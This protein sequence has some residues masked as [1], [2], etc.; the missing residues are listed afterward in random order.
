MLDLDTEFALLNGEKRGKVVLISV[1]DGFL[2]RG[3]ENKL[4]EG[5]VPVT[6][7]SASVNEIAPLRDEASMYLFNLD[8]GIADAT[9]FLVYLK[10][11]CEEDTKRILVVGSRDEYAFV[12]RVI[13]ERFVYEWL[14]R[15]LD[16]TV[17]L[18]KTQACLENSSGGQR[19]T[20]LIVD[21]DVTYVKIIYEWL[22]DTYQVGM[23]TSGMQAITWLAKH[24]TDLILLDYEMPV[25]SGPQVL[26][27]LKSDSETNRVPV[28]FLTG[29]GDRESVM[30]VMGLRP[31]DYLLKTITRTALQQKLDEF[32][33]T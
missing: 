22:R 5:G 17:L 23:A 25:T 24:K 15:P 16:M 4:M 14:E 9:D 18:K 28:M 3:I 21:D 7:I 29:K 10:D 19:K 33:R 13:P 32:F 8:D 6:H 30:S 1:K 27:M 11:V 12:T 2:V 31:V 20:I 26:E